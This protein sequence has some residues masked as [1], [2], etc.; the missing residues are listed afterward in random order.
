[1]TVALVL[2]NV[3][4][5]GSLLW[6]STRRDVSAVL[7]ISLLFVYVLWY[8]V[9]AAITIL[10][11]DRI[12]SRVLTTYDVFVKYAVIEAVALLLTLVTFGI[13]WRRW[14]WM[15]DGRLA[16]LTIGRRGMT[17][18]VVGSV[19]FSLLIRRQILGI[20]GTNYAEANAFSV[21]SEGTSSAATVGILF[22]ISTILQAFLVTCLLTPYPRQPK[23]I[24]PLLWIWLLVMTATEVLVGSRMA[25]LVP[26]V[27]LLMWVHQ[28]R[29]SRTALVMIYGGIAFFMATVGVLLTIV[30]AQI[31]S[32]NTIT[33]AAARQESQQMVSDGTSRAEQLWTFFDHIYLKFDSI[34]PGAMLVEGRGAGAAGVKPWIGA[35]LSV[36]PRRILPSKP[37]PGSIDGTYRGTPQRIMAVDLG[38]DPDFGNVGVSPAAISIWQFGMLGLLPLILINTLNLR[39]MNSMLMTR[40]VFTRMVPIIVLNIPAFTG[41]FSN[42]DAILMGGERAFAVYLAASIGLWLAGITMR[43]PLTAAR[44]TR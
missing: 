23:L 10:A 25:L 19:L 13:G 26:C 5:V 31:R 36:V 11:W 14:R 2:L 32:Q 18:L 16:N 44:A 35:A 38:Y 28:R 39:M 22:F 40:S 4:I 17:W 7:V 33:V 21:T 34:G 24:A 8:F 6:V 42:G 12:A 29:L 43:A 9:P 41:V 15:A 3:L 1:M 27:L 37:V 20:V 30:I